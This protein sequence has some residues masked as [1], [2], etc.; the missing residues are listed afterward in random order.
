MRLH[1]LLLT[2]TLT[3]AAAFGAVTAQAA[4]LTTGLTQGVVSTITT[5][6]ND[7]Y[8]VVK[9]FKITSATTGPVRIDVPANTLA[10]PKLYLYGTDTSAGGISPSIVQAPLPL[11]V[12]P[13]GQS[14]SYTDPVSVTTALSDV[15]TAAKLASTTLDTSARRL[16][17]SAT[18]ITS[19]ET[20]DGRLE[21]RVPVKYRWYRQ[22]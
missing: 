16:D 8:S 14:V 6:H 9:A 3:L 13:D 15:T 20:L 18:G 12:I 11:A 21:Y 10:A 7:E 22:F 19:T 5:R 2:A 1:Q 4:N 17:I